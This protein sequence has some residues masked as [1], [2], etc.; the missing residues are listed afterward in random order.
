ME[1][2]RGRR[3]PV[4][5]DCGLSF[6]DEP[7]AGLS[8]QTVNM[9]SRGVLVSVPRTAHLPAKLTV[10]ETARVVLELPHA[11]Y[12]RGCWLECMCR[13]ARVLNQRDARLVAFEVKR[14][15]FRP[16]LENA[17]NDT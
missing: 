13:V 10:G 11:P 6:R 15:Q 4:R 16:S 5:L 9:S 12:F 8:G 7:T 1:R 17:S 14:Y 3:Y 2:R